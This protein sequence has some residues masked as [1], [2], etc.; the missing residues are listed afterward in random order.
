[1][2]SDKIQKITILTGILVAGGFFAFSARKKVRC[3]NQ[4]GI[5]DPDNGPLFITESAA[6]QIEDRARKRIKTLLLSKEVIDLAEIKLQVANDIR[7]CDWENLKTDEQRAV[8]NAISKIVNAVSD[9]ADANRD[10]FHNSF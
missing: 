6:D 9:A 1:M 10:E 5:Y 4:K 7:E 3:S 2:S 8:W